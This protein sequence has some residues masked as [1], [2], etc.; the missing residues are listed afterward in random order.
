[1]CDV[2]MFPQEFKA[3]EEEQRVLRGIDA[4]DLAF[5][6]AANKCPACAR[7]FLVLPGGRRSDVVPL[8]NS[9]MCHMPGDI[10]WVCAGEEGCQQLTCRCGAK[11]CYRCR[12]VLT[13][14]HPR[15]G[16]AWYH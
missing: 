10:V 12:A 5:M 6:N 4:A 16:H 3:W 1:M 11:F 9:V 7:P 8:V 13:P 2:I 15:C 14:Q